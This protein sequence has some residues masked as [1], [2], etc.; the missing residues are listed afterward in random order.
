MKSWTIF[1][2]DGQMMAFE[3]PEKI[4][5]LELTKSCGADPCY[6]KDHKG[7]A[8]L[9]HRDEA[10]KHKKARA[11]ALPVAEDSQEKILSLC[12]YGFPDKSKEYQLECEM[13]VKTCC[14]E[15]LLFLTE[16]KN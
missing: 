8:C 7:A 12:W 2:K 16:P 15:K 9:C 1:W 11:S 10:I 13:E 4:I 3:T 14:I 6:H 5:G